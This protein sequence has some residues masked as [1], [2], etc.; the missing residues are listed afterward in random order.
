MAFSIHVCISSLLKIP[1]L[2]K[3][4]IQDIQRQ[5]KGL[6]DELGDSFNIPSDLNL[7]TLYEIA[8]IDQLKGDTYQSSRGING[9][10]G[11]SINNNQQYNIV[12]NANGVSVEQALNVIKQA[13]TSPSRTGNDARI[14]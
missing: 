10:T 7:P 5:I 11:G 1:N 14:Y 4:Q 9:I 13:V 12:I 3:K 6:R 8:R 2:T